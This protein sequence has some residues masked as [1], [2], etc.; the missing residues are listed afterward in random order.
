MLSLAI[1]MEKAQ[2]MSFSKLYEVWWGRDRVGDF[3]T[4]VIINC[5]ARLGT[6]S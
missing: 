2:L 5:Q 6:G 1:T 3:E 4:F